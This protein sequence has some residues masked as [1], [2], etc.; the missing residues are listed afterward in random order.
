MSGSTPSPVIAEITTTSSPR[1]AAREGVVD[2]IRLGPDH[3][4]RAPGELRVVGGE[5]R[6]QG[7]EVGGGVLC[8]QVDDE[9]E[10]PTA[11]NVA[12][13]PVA[14]AFPVGGALD[15]PGHVGDD[16][17]SGV[18]A[19]HAEV[20]RQ[21]RERIVGDLGPR[22]REARQQRRLP[23]FGRPTSPTSATVRS[24]RAE[25]PLLRRL[26][27]LGYLRGAVPRRR[28]HRVPSAAA[29]PRPRPPRDAL[30]DEVGQ[31]SALVEDDRAVGHGSHIV[32]ARPSRLADRPAARSAPSDADGRR[33]TT[34]RARRRAPPGR[35]SRRRRRCPRRARPMA[36]TARNASRPTRRRRGRRSRTRCTRPRRPASG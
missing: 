33:T 19:G 29:T 28:E 9:D 23:A 5:L 17:P 10:R 12:Q 18:A 35:R 32:A 30:A 3:D 11:H 2:E 21:R 25:G 4:G 26:A 22:G 14:K 7:G 6:S 13:E 8:R 34:D 16:E 15:E 36:C 20:R 27:W 1:A 24:S 31:Q